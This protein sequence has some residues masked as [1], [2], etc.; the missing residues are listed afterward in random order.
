M[1]IHHIQEDGVVSTKVM[2]VF[3]QYNCHI[4][5]KKYVS[6][7]SEMS[8]V[9]TS[10]GDLIFTAVLGNK[11]YIAVLIVQALGGSWKNAYYG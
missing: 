4:V 10:A 7:C 9:L 5:V 2:H 11:W 8:F 6:V 3:S 1:H